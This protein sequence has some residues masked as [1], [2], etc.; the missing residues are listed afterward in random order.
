MF[1]ELKINGHPKRNFKINTLELIKE[2]KELTCIPEIA[3][4]N[5]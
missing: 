4:H 5:F 3:I 2:D 1:A